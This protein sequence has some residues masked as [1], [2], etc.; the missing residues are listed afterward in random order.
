[1]IDSVG[2]GG[3]FEFKSTPMNYAIAYCGIIHNVSKT[4]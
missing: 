4:H 2:F 3:L 1:M